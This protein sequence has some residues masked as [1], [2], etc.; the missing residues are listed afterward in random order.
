MIAQH[1]H[2]WVPWDERR[3]DVC[4]EADCYATKAWDRP[5]VYERE[6]EGVRSL[7]CRVRVTSVLQG[8][9]SE[10][11]DCRKDAAVGVV[12]FSGYIEREVGDPLPQGAGLSL[13]PV[14]TEHAP[15]L[16]ETVAMGMDRGEWTVVSLAYGG[17]QGG[18][19]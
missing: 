1:V 17:S 3:L 9:E 8:E 15:H 12:T 18:L 16:T 2:Q 7:R 10:A 4:D 11:R 13:F 14:C 5:G 19:R 6:P